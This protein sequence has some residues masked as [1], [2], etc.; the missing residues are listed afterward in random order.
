MRDVSS[1]GTGEDSILS[2]KYTM[3]TRPVKQSDSEEKKDHHWHSTVEN[4]NKPLSE[5][6]LE[7]Y[8]EKVRE[9]SQRRRRRNIKMC[10]ADIYI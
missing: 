9:L 4:G 2:I 5:R 3:L 1:K 6:G 7:K 8:Q 10:C